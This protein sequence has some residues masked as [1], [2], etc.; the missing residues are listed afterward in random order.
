M[1]TFT[2]PGEKLNKSFNNRKRPPTFRVQGQTCHLIGSLLPMLGDSP[3][4]AQLYIY[5]TKMKFKIG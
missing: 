1:F 4:L 2:S 3:V 5:D